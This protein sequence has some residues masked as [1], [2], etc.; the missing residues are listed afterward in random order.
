MSNIVYGNDC[1]EEVPAHVCTDC[2]DVENGRVSSVA[3]IKK[4][5]ISTLKAD[6]S[7][8]TTWTTGILSGAIKIIPRTS[9]SFAQESV[10]GNGY[11]RVKERLIGYANTLTYR[12]PD[13]KE[14]WGFYNGM[15]DAKSYH[16]AYATE[17]LIHISDEPVTIKPL[18]PVED[19]LNSEVTWNVEV[20]WDQGPLI[21]PVPQPDGIFD[22]FSVTP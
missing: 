4:A 5:Y 3:F 8:P 13:Y 18:Q 2:G 12:D 1:E 15:K 16:V 19:D 20:V 10:T 7:N 6:P 14:N 21:R 17:T 22:C 9:G 11:G